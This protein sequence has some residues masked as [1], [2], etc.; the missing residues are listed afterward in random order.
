MP[1]YQIFSLQINYSYCVQQSAVM[2][3]ILRWRLWPASAA[4]KQW[5]DYTKKQKALRALQHLGQDRVSQLQQVCVWKEWK[6]RLETNKLAVMHRVSGSLIN[7][8]IPYCL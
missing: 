8:E 7:F 4:F 5:L 6:R 1:N 2:V 3:A